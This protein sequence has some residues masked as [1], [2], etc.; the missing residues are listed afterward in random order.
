[1]ARNGINVFAVSRG[2]WDHDMFADEAFSEREAWLW[3]I[4]EAAWKGARVRVG[5]YM[6]N[7]ERGQ[8]S[9]SVRFMADKWGWHRA[10]VERFLKRLKTETMIETDARH[11]VTI[12][13]I[14]NYGEYQKVGLPDRTASE[15][16]SET[17]PRQLRDREETGETGKQ[18]DTPSGERVRAPVS[19]SPS[20][21]PEAELFDLGRKLLGKSAGGQVTR[22]RKA[23]G[24]D[25]AQVRSLLEQAAE[26]ANPSEWIAAVL[27]RHENAAYEGVDYEGRKPWGDVPRIKSR[28][29][30]D[31]DAFFERQYR[32]VH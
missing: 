24:F 20:R 27:K 10:K 22:L 18:E 9:H 16:P 29:E 13:T 1:M 32:G 5:N 7:L 25:D 17:V 6:V 11:G 14:C 21:S 31:L 12:I 26:K 2:I 15:T 19:A 3:L 23:T 30:R 28:E 8:L 4:S